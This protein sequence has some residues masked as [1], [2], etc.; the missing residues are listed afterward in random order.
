MSISEIPLIPSTP[1][2]MSITLGGVVFQ[3]VFKWNSVLTAWIM[4]M[5]D[6]VGNPIVLGTPL[7]TGADLLAQYGYFGFTGYE[8]QAVTS[9][10]DAPPAFDNLG[11]TSHLYLVT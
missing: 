8:L 6:A 10:S 1:Q 9:G 2:S 3:L 5:L 7:V 11:T 4:D